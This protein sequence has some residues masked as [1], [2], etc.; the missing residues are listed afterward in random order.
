MILLR[1]I[2]GVA[3]AFLLGVTSAFVERCDRG[4]RYYLTGESRLRTM[5]SEKIVLFVFSIPPSP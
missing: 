2:F 3:L 4:R 1:L 5:P